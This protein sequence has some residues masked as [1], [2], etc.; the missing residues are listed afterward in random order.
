MAF[1]Q[2]RTGKIEMEES[3]HNLKVSVCVITYNQKDYIRQCLQ[4]IVD[5][6]TDFEYQII[7]GDDCS[8]DGTIEIIC[9]FE[10]KY[11]KKIK[12]IFHKVNTGSMGNYL[13]VHR[14]ATGDYVCHIDGDDWMRPDKLRLQHDFLE[15]NS[16]CALVTH[17][18]GIWDSEELVELTKSGPAFIDLSTLLRNHPIFMH[19]SIMYRRSMIQDVFSLDRTFID[20]FVYVSA[21]MIG[22]IGFLN[23]VLGDYRRNIGISSARNLMPLIQAAVDHAEENGA[24]PADVKRCRAKSYLSYAVAALCKGEQ[25]VFRSH[26]AASVRADPLWIYPNM[27][28]IAGIMPGMLR[29][30]ILM[31]KN[32]PKAT[33]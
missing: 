33:C 1:A 11:P 4:S 3:M 31:Y 10:R 29:W 32:R 9:E 18:V 30:M 26:L 15:K 2:W 20:F 14:A 25:E 12:P 23:Q 13:S 22:P 16:Q 24:L 17:R 19:S 8:T 27:I 6:Q 7:V 5:Q 21:A 28:R